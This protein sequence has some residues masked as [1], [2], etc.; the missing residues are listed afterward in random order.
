MTLFCIIYSCGCLGIFS[1]R[2]H[3]SWHFSAAVSKRFK[4]QHRGLYLIIRFEHGRTGKRD[5]IWILLA[6]FI[7]NFLCLWLSQW[8]LLSGEYLT[9]HKGIQ[10]N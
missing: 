3:L 5:C 6:S 10:D 1:S 8:L 4:K 9:I 7:R 2:L